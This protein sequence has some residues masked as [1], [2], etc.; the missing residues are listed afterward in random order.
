MAVAVLRPGCGAAWPGGT[1]PGAHAVRFMQ[2]RASVLYLVSTYVWHRE[3]AER[4]R[5][6]DHEAAMANVRVLFLLFLSPFFV[7]FIPCMTDISTTFLMR[8]SP[9]ICITIVQ[10]REE[11]GGDQTRYLAEMEAMRTQ[12]LNK[13]VMRMKMR[14]VSVGFSLWHDSWKLQVRDFL[15]S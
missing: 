5:L 7:F 12:C 1:A 3:A 15:I 10:L 8:A 4:A 13:V 9:I 14:Q 6:G 11:R 2:M